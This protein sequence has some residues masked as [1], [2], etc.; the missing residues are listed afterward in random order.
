M[1]TLSGAAATC[2]SEQF[3]LSLTGLE[4]FKICCLSWLPD[5]DPGLSETDNSDEE[6]KG[7]DKCIY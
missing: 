7:I 2:T 3:H 6:A 4:V 5:D 1:E